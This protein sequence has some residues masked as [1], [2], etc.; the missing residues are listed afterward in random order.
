MQEIF[1]ITNSKEVKITKIDQGIICFQNEKGDN[2]EISTAHDVAQYCSN[3]YKNRKLFTYDGVKIQP[4]GKGNDESISKVSLVYNQ[5]EINFFSFIINC[6]A[7]DYKNSKK[8]EELKKTLNVTQVI[9]YLEKLIIDPIY[10]RK[11]YDYI[12]PEDL[13]VLNK[14]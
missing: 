4:I 1:L 14:T 2:V 12:N 8:N 11:L 9:S 13:G 10:T 3:D 5:E 6:L 7:E